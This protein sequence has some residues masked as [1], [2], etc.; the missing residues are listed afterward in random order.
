VEVK[1]QHVSEDSNE[2][3]HN[4]DLA[5]RRNNTI[6]SAQDRGKWDTG[7]RLRELC[8]TIP[9]LAAPLGINGNCAAERQQK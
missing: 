6:P 7:R 2:R 9:E 8:P 1:T 3:P 5:Q 4:P